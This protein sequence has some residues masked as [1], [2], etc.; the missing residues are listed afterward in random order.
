M[1]T[2][3]THPNSR[4]TIYVSQLALSFLVFA[5]KLCIQRQRRADR[6]PKTSVS[7]S[8]GQAFL[9]SVVLK[10][11]PLCS[12]HAQ[13]AE[14]LGTLSPSF[15]LGRLQCLF[16]SEMHLIRE[17]CLTSSLHINLIS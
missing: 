17:A 5:V 7:K 8:T 12:H 6:Y 1:V 13:G 16:T 2:P 4:Q 10:S 14:Q 3:K 15:V 9:P 11:L